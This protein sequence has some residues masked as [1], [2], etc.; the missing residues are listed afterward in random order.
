MV[1]SADLEGKLSKLL[2]EYREDGLG[3]L[4]IEDED[5]FGSIADFSSPCQLEVFTVSSPVRGNLVI[6]TNDD[7]RKDGE[8][9]V[10]GPYNPDTFLDEVDEILEKP[11]WRQLVDEETRADILIP[12]IRRFIERGQRRLFKE[13]PSTGPLATASR[14]FGAIYQYWGDLTE[15][16]ADLMR[17]ETRILATSM[18]KSED[19]DVSITEV[20]AESAPE[21]EDEESEE[22]EEVEVDEVESESAIGTFI[23]EPVWVGGE[24][25]KSAREQVLSQDDIPGFDEE[26]VVTSSV[27]DCDVRFFKNGLVMFIPKMRT[28]HWRF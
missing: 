3:D 19:G 14:P 9:L 25:D 28:R 10:N 26:P 20:L 5:N 2:S 8:I 15:D 4:E 17:R 22:D 12:I 11:R 16:E 23:Y 13:N 6:K 21:A 18:A 24:P 27:S 7:N 1:E